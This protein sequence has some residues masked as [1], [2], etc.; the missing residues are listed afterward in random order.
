MQFKS[1]LGAIF[2]LLLAATTACHKHDDDANA[3]VLTIASPTAGE[4]VTGEIHIEG[5]ATDESLHEMEI[6]ITKDSD[7][8][9][10]YKATPE[11]HDLTE[12]DFHEH[13]TPTL[14]A[15][16]AV[17]LTVTVSDHSDHTTTQTVKFTVKP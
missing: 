4:S 10:L 1:L 7:G 11:V 5:K 13:Y 9:E 6:K 17:T 15:E 16:T 8:S 12:Y 3:P 2:C 14:S